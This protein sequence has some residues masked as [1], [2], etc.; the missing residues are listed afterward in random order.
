MYIGETLEELHAG[1]APSVAPD[2]PFTHVAE[3]LGAYDHLIGN[4]EC[5][6]SKKG[7]IETQHAPFR[8]PRAAVTAL[9]RGGFDLVSVANN[10]A[11]DF[12]QRGFQ[13][14]LKNLDADGMPHFGA[15]A[16]SKKRQAPVITV[17]AGK[18][19]GFLA[20]YWPPKPPLHDVIEA[21]KNVDILMVFNH[22]G[23]DDRVEPMMLQRRLARHFIDAG[24]D[25]VVGTHSHVV[26][27]FEW[28][29]GKL[30]AYG[31][32]NFVFDGMNDTEVHS[33]GAV[34]EVDVTSQGVSGH[35]LQR[36]RLGD[37]GV[38]R[39]I[40][41]PSATVDLVPQATKPLPG[42]AAPVP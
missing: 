33:I 17:L 28:Y 4:L 1:R 11:L 38:P 21:R 5:V 16:F 3:R 8:C 7:D 26:Q 39:W 23:Q 42:A 9:K 12:G 22:W 14:M 30:V 36:I 19:V 24:V 18:R 32:G 29:K 13:D 31:L 2:F 6:L 20:Y 41:D 25:V 15:E 37:D 34:L 40:G 10:H 35:R 27:P